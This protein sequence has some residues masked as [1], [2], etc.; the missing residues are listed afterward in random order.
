M[1]RKSC[2]NYEFH[3]LFTELH[4]FCTVDL[5]SFYLDVRKDALYCDQPDSIQRRATR[6]VLDQ[7][8]N[9]LTSWF[10]PF[11]CFTAEEA[12]LARFPNEDDSIHLKQFP[13]IPTIWENDKLAEKWSRIREIRRVVTGAL[14]IERAEKRIGSSLQ[15]APTVYVTKEY[16]DAMIGLD[17]AEIT[18]TSSAKL[19]EGEAP[20]GAF[21]IEDV[22]GVGVIPQIAEG[23]KCIRCFKVLSEVGTI[24]DHTD[25][26]RRCAV[27]TDQFNLKNGNLAP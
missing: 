2:A 25:V 9:C 7:L 15:A 23:N 1:I 3:S 21:T 18:I 13:Q 12:W 26:C 20:T 22:I 5:S 19:H 14:E 10:A 11:I 16:I 6:T 8:F 4:N 27:A 17:L 24:A